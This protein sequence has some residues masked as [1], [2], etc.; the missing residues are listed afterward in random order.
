LKVSSNHKTPKEKGEIIFLRPQSV[1]NASFS[2]SLNEN[3]RFKHRL[4]NFVSQ[5]CDIS[6]IGSF[7]FSFKHISLIKNT[8][9]TQT[10]IISCIFLFLKFVPLTRI[11]DV[12]ESKIVQIQSYAQ[13]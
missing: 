3:L 4:K 9:A 6:T 5:N 7:S 12:T 1:E 13:M 8:G 2:M 10:P 11:S